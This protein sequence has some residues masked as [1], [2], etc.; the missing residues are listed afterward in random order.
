MYLFLLINLCVVLP[1]VFLLAL[2]LS[3]YYCYKRFQ[4]LKTEKDDL[5]GNVKDQR[6]LDELS[7]ANLRNKMRKTE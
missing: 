6:I 4:K 7:K 2:V 1:I 3:L 5:E